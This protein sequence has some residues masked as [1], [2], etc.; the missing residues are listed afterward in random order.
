MNIP[1]D[2]N[3]TLPIEV[4]VEK[5]A[6]LNRRLYPLDAIN[7]EMLDSPQ[8]FSQPMKIEGSVSTLEEDYSSPS[9][10]KPRARTP[11][12]SRSRSNL[13]VNDDGT[14]NSKEML[15]S[16]N[17]EPESKSKR[18]REED[19]GEG[20]GGQPP[21]KSPTFRA[22]EDPNGEYRCSYLITIV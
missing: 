11:N 13:E 18:Q 2:V 8:R 20:T 7:A 19:R 6:Q 4:S 21:G 22:V 5:M 1:V 16:D 9:G 14:E 12:S 15:I 3:G 17:L 10:A